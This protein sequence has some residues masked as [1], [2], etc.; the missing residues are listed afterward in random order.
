MNKFRKNLT[1]HFDDQKVG[2]NPHATFIS[3]L[4]QLAGLDTRYMNHSICVTGVTNLTRSHY[5]PKQI[6]SMTGH[7]SL[8]S[9]SIYQKVKEDE[10]MMMD[11]SLMY[12]LMHPGVV[13]QVMNENM[14][15]FEL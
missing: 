13:Q 8:Q 1:P 14:P 5:T 4:A 15:L 2:K 3:D 7:K 12:S 9:L 6:M 11:K 10:K